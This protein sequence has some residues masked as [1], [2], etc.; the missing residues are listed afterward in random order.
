MQCH[1]FQHTAGDI[2]A[3]RIEHC[4]VIGERNVSQHWPI[5]V[6]VKRRP[7]TVL[8]LHRHQPFQRPLH[9][10]IVLGRTAA[11]RVAERDHHHPGIVDI[12]VI[13]VGEF[14]VPAGG[15]DIGAMITPVAFLANFL[16]QQPF[17]ALPQRRRRRRPSLGQRMDRNRRVPHHGEAR[18]EKE[19]LPVIHH[20]VQEL[21][22]GLVPVR[23]AGLNAQHV[24][25]H[26]RV[27]HR[28]VD[29][30]QPIGVTGPVQYP[31]FAL[32]NRLL[33]NRLAAVPLP[34]L[35]NLVH[36]HEEGLPGNQAPRA[37]KRLRNARRE[38]LVDR[39]PGGHRPPRIQRLH[40][41]QRHDDR[42]GPRA[43]MIK[44]AAHQNH[45]RRHRRHMLARIQVEEAQVDLD[46]AIGRLQAAIRQ[47]RIP[48]PRH[49]RAGRVD[50]R[51]F[52]RKI[53]LHRRANVRRP[54]GVNRKSTVGALQVQDRLH[55]PVHLRPR[56]GIPNGA[57][58]RV[59]PQLQ[60][61]IVG[62]QRRI[63]RQVTPP[64]PLFALLCQQ[65][66]GGLRDRLRDASG[67]RIRCLQ[68][69]AHF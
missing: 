5:V 13:L 28:R 45:L 35:A 24:Q 44:H 7:A 11:A 30:G 52:Q 60:Q 17:R 54:A 55:S 21:L 9:G 6:D 15:L 57:L 59:Q 53:R 27:H 16:A 69:R 50:T 61:D 18:L 14:K 56:R 32:G 2:G 3:S 47:H 68:T 39:E 48:Q 63:R 40:N 38:Q 46:V 49:G 25:R 1:R 10:G 66:V 29:R 37:R 36:A 64:I 65:P 33:A 42:P 12:G 51:H 62:L 22:F 19:P 43:H 41:R 31:L 26:D 8:G 58:R 4:V 23:M 67:H 34:Q 20:Q